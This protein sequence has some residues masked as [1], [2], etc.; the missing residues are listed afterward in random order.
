MKTGI[1]LNSVTKIMKKEKNTRR[2]RIIKI[3]IEQLL[4]SKH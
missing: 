3:K 4:I 2:T 1:I